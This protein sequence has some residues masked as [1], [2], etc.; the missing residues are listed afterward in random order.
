LSQN[1]T[2]AARLARI[3]EKAADTAKAKHLQL[4]SAAAAGAGSAELVQLRSVK[5]PSLPQ[6]KGQGEFTLVFD[7]SGRP[8][9]VDFNSGDDDLRGAEPT[10]LDADYPVLFPEYTSA[11]IVRRGVLSCSA[12]GCLVT[13]KPLEQPKTLGN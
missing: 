8:Q 2:V 9:R 13:L 12:G 4:L 5:M 7:G 11:K 1:G 10:L 6:K 3:Y